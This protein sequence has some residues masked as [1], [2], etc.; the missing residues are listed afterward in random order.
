MKEVV[1]SDTVKGIVKASDIV[2]KLKKVENRYESSKKQ[3]NNLYKDLD[4]V[5]T[6][7]FKTNE[8]KILW[9][10]TGNYKTKDLFKL[11]QESNNANYKVGIKTSE[12]IKNINENS[13]ALSEMTGDLAMLTGLSFK[14][15][16]ETTEEL[17]KLSNK[18]KKGINGVGGNS[19]NIERVILSQINR[20]KEEKRKQEKYDYNFR[21]IN[22]NL[23]EL[24]KQVKD[25][26]KEIDRKN[27]EIKRLFQS[28]SED[29]FIKVL[30]RQKKMINLLFLI[31]FIL[32]SIQIITIFYI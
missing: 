13:I 4:S 19:N 11:I 18:L 32:I 26:K 25:Y 3:V 30:K 9:I 12:L 29:H 16:S 1:I 20:V 24:Q 15:I 23:K 7:I 31:S 27:K 21:V 8:K 22:D 14:K 5:R 28:S 10:E 17:D 2:N 6:S